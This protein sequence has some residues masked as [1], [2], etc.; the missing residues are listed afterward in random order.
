MNIM[1]S[2][3]KKTKDMLSVLCINI[4]SVVLCV[5]LVFNVISVGVALINRYSHVISKITSLNFSSYNICASSTYIGKLLPMFNIQNY[6][7]DTA[8]AVENEEKLE[9]EPQEKEYAF[10]GEAVN[11]FSSGVNN[12]NEV[13]I[14]YSSNYQKVKL[15]GITLYNYSAKTNLDYTSFIDRKINLS[16]DK[17]KILLYCTH[18]S[19]SYV[20]SEKYQFEYT[21]TMRTK[22][23]K[24]NMLSVASVL[25]NALISKNFNVVLDTT[26]HD[27]A[28]YDS[29]YQNSIKTIQKQL[30]TNGKYRINYRCA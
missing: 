13:S 25:K 6:V 5:L 18:T 26:P 1:V 11:T 17:D 19:E 15:Y 20:N 12:N 24:Y 7:L 10:S 22:D 4:K 16:R 30:D 29:A 14:T 2:F 21:G 9:V 3:F 23:A 27:Y 28:S 8:V